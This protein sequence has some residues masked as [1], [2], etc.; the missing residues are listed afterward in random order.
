[1]WPGI[2]V[3]VVLMLVGAYLSF[4][5]IALPGQGAIRGLGIPADLG[6]TIATI[7][8]FL[9]L[10]PVIKF[11]FVQ[12]LDDAI[13]DR[14]QSLESTFSE[15]ENLRNE[16]Q[17]M[18]TEYE[19]RIAATESNARDQIQSQ[20]REAQNLRAQLMSEAS[21]RADEMV[22]RAHQEIEAEKVKAIAELRL[23]VVDLTLTAAERILGENMDNDRNR[24][25]VN[26]FID[27]VEVP[28]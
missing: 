11:F 19:Q 12:P 22:S 7:G 9:V 2:A 6:M 1:M 17:A 14:T 23:Q 27:K 18:R 3:G 28:V 20:I 13:T 21:A 5:E 26:D 25:L 24:R 16:M 4:N 10:F 15:A 8:V